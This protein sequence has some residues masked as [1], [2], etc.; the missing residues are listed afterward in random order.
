MPV[1][2]FPILAVYRTSSTCGFNSYTEFRN[3]EIVRSPFSN[4]L[5]LWHQFHLLRFSEGDPA[6]TDGF[7]KTVGVTF[8]LLLYFEQYL[9]SSEA[10]GMVF[11]LSIVPVLVVV[12]S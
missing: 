9:F 8:L 2:L 10:S 12:F 5:L 7:S 1:S 4:A 11:P 6:V 3:D